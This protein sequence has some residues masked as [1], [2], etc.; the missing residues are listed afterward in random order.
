MAARAG[1]LLG[2]CGRQ[3]VDCAVVMRAAPLSGSLA[4]DPSTATYQLR[5][6]TGPCLSV[7]WFT[8]EEASEDDNSPYLLGWCKD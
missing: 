2:P 1:Q 8:L 7:P 3:K 4:S 5:T 6:W